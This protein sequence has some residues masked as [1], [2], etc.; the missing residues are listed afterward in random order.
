MALYSAAWDGLTD[1]ERLGW[2]TAASTIVKKNIFG[3]KYY[4]TGNKLFIAF[5][6][7]AALNGGTSTINSYFVPTAPTAIVN[8]TGLA[9]SS[10]AQT[11]TFTASGAAPTNGVVIVQATP[12]LKQGISNIKGKYRVV[13]RS[14]KAASAATI[15]NLTSAYIARLGE[16]TQ[17]TRI[18]VRLYTTNNDVNGQVIK[19]ASSTVMSCIVS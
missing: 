2:V 19:Y 4:T 9:A 15:G 7:E 5:N 14:A 10:S 1:G 16:L 17:N 11:V 8:G 12:C 18:Y 13:S 3:A 6:I